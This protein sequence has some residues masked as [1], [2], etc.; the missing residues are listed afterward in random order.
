VAVLGK[1]TT[2][3]RFSTVLPLLPTDVSA[4]Y[5]EVSEKLPD[6]HGEH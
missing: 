6:E 1:P 2:V 3:Q 4:R 5:T